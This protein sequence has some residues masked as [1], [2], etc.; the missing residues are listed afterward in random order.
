SKSSQPTGAG[1]AGSAAPSAAPA[2]SAAA[3]RE[4]AKAPVLE[5]SAIVRAAGEDAVYIAD[6]DHKVVRR[7]PLPLPASRANIR[8][9]IPP[10]GAPAQGLALA[11]RVLVTIRDPGLLLIMKPDNDKGLVEAG[12]VPLPADA[13]GVSATADEATALVTSAWTHKVSAVDLTRAEVK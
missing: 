13:W 10:P 6:E 12:R 3:A 1:P 7:V 9:A 5:G 2:G 4:K 11:D 8:V